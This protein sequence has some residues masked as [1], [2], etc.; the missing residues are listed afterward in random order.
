[1][2][3]WI[4]VTICEEQVS[5]VL[6][7]AIIPT[8]APHLTTQNPAQTTIL[9]HILAYILEREEEWEAA[10]KVMMGIPLENTARMISDQQKVDVYMKIVRLLIEV[11][12]FRVAFVCQKE[13]MES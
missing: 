10:A 13:R 2:V 12:A 1:M 4:A 5:R 8:F 7:N 11:S 6:I 3:N 9:R